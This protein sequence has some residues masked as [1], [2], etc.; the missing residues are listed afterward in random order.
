MTAVLGLAQPAAAQPYGAG[1]PSAPAYSYDDA[2]QCEQVK[3]GR[4]AGG[5]LLGAI[6][7]AVIGNNVAHD[8]SDGSVAG[9]V[10]GG[11]AGGAIAR[12]S[13]RCDGY[14]QGDGYYRDP[15]DPNYGDPRD[16]NYRDRRSDDRSGLYGG[17]G[18]PRYDRGYEPRYAQRAC[19]WRTMR[20]RDDWGRPH[21][22]RVYM[23]EGRDGR[24]RPAR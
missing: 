12:N 5:A 10:V 22:E 19:E 4:T 16:P 15:R 17:P 7:G 20:W 2:R 3:N 13:V 18:D 6:I 9:A 21:R 24:W 23:C 1:P 11:V 14:S 8:Q